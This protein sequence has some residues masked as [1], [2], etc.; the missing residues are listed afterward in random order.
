[1]GN[2][3]IQRAWEKFIENGAT[4]NAVRGVVAAS[5]ERSQEYHIPIERSETRV[6]PEAELVHR[7]SE[8]SELLAAAQPALEPARALL[9]EASSM[10][11][12]TDPSGVIIDTAGDPRTIAVAQMIHLEQGGHWA[13]AD[14]GTNAIGTAIAALQPVQ[15]H[16]VENFCSEVQRRH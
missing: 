5:W 10:V 15:I 8:H 7:R 6:E 13:E 16:A 2:L 9:A 3:E 12:V 1:M 14:I 11:I 4:S